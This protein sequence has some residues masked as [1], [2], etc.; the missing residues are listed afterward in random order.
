M[1]EILITPRSFASTS[2]RPLDILKKKGYELNIN[3]TGESYTRDQMKRL[4][5]GKE[6][7]IIG[8][9]P[10]DKDI[11]AGAD[12][13]KVISKYGVGL[14]NIDLKVAYKQEIKVTNTPLANTASVADLAFGLI[15]SS[16]R[17]ITEADR[18]TAQGFTGKIV[19]NQVWNKTLG[20]IGLGSIGQQVAARARG[21]NMDVLCYD[22]NKNR[23]FAE[24]MDFEYVKLDYLLTESDFISLHLPLNEK[25]ENFIS[26]PQLEL[27]KQE[28]HLINTARG[29][30]LNEQDLFAALRQGK[31]KSAALDDFDFPAN[32]VPEDIRDKIILTPHMGAHTKEAIENMGVQAAENMI[33]VLEG[34]TPEDLVN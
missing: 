31:I 18:K 20:I 29:G 7:V 34:E 17:C 27:M 11:L 23:N 8:T 25:T 3:D 33:S 12:S 28:A 6:G 19:G 21:F 24:I 10:L 1:T 13:L 22:I 9:D 30:V 14:D 16:A 5:K 32:E 15:L 26:A 2:S 4:I